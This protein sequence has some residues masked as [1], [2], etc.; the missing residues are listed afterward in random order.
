MSAPEE[1]ASPWKGY[2]LTLQN[3]AYTLEESSIGRPQPWKVTVLE[4]SG[5]I[6]KKKKMDDIAPQFD[7]PEGESEK[8]IRGKLNMR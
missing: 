7:Y 2:A 8:P 4:P 1:P 6:E 3:A 5:K